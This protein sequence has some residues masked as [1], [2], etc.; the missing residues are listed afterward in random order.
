MS[1]SNSH[2]L[3]F[4]WIGLPSVGKLYTLKRNKSHVQLRVELP[5]HLGL[6]VGEKKRGSALSDDH[7]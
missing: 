5:W 1:I 2:T 3:R 7:L 6:G 4:F